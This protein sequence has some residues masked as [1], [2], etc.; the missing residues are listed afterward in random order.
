MEKQ[1]LAQIRN[2]FKFFLSGAYRIIDKKALSLREVYLLEEMNRIRTTLLEEHSQTSR[3][4][5]LTVKLRCWCG[6]TRKTDCGEEYCR[7]NLK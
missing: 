4:M 5:G 7:E 1:K 3:D 6:K 2:R